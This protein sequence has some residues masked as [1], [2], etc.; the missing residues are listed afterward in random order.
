MHNKTI[1][2]NEAQGE[3]TQKTPFSDID[4]NLIKEVLLLMYKNQITQGKTPEQ[5][6]ALLK[7]Q[8]PFNNYED[9][10]DELQ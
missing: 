3:E 6:K 2:I 8:E 9:L 7:T 1:Y 5:A 4:T 10:I